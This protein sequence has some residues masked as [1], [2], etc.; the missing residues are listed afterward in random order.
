[1]SDGQ[2]QLVLFS[3]ITWLPGHRGAGRELGEVLVVVVKDAARK[4]VRT[5][6]KKKGGGVMRNRRAGQ[7]KSTAIKKS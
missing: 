4:A 2:P 6:Q 3:S 7:K 1:M 5:V